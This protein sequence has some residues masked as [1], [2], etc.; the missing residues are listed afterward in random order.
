MNKR[1]LLVSSLLLSVAG[2]SQEKAKDSVEANNEKVLQTVE[3]I[4]RARKDYSSDYSF[5]SSKIA[6]KNMEVAQSI[7][8]VTKELLA[9][10]QVFR[11][12][13]AVK[14]VSGVTNTS[15]YNHYSI[16]GVTQASGNREN[17]LINGMSTSTYYF[18]QPLT[19]N[20]ERIEVIKGPA[21][22][23]FSSTDPG[24]TINLVTKKPLKNAR[25]E[26]SFTVGSYGTVRGALDFTGPLN[27]SK[28]LLYRLNIGYE[29]SQSYRDLQ[30]KKAYI[31]A[32]TISYIPNE[33][34]SVNVEFVL[35]DDTS[36]L[37]RG[38]PIY[39]VKQGEKPSLNTT[40]I[41]LAVGAPNDYNRNIDL[42]IMG[43]LTHKFT[44]D[45]NLNMSYMKHIWNEDLSEH[46]ANGANA[47]VADASGKYTLVEVRYVARQQ[48]FFTDNFNAY[49]N[50]NWK[51]GES[52]KNKTVFGYDIVGFE[53]S[54]TGGYNQAR[55][56]A[57]GVPRFDLANPKYY[58]ENPSAYNFVAKRKYQITPLAYTTN[59][60][61]LMNHMEWNKFIF[62][63]GLRQ[64]WFVD[65]YNYKIEGKEK[66]SR[67]NKFSKRF[68]LMYKANK[69]I[70]AYASY[71]EGFQIQTDAYI[72][73]DQY[74]FDVNGKEVYKE[75]F[76]PAS[77]RMWE[78]GLK[79]EWLNGKLAANVAYFNIKQRNILIEDYADATNG[80][81]ELHN[82]TDSRSQGIE[83]DVTGRILPNL[84]VNAGYSYIDAYFVEKDGTKSEKGN[85]PKHSFNLWSRY[86]VR[87]GVL[88]NFGVGAG[89]NYVGEKRA[90]LERNNLTVPSYAVVDAAVYYKLKD[91]Q[92]AVNVSNLFNTKYWL[93]AFDY[94]RLFPGSP[95]NVMLNVRY[96]F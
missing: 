83:V 71:I 45:I 30:F 36:R 94:T 6:L 42:S 18:N 75:P 68:G 48:K 21:S 29:N 89:L 16:R 64:E 1:V 37:D 70:N 50:A 8:S 59:G 66:V 10:R 88:R 17:R 51:I 14:N 52:I 87:E 76:G 93:G 7:S 86:D 20:I 73:S 78:G 9:D 13:D 4:G 40:P 72:G 26:V 80:G 60:I 23:A 2:F 35:S 63:F 55:G 31:I 27:E 79:T 47:L 62:S 77:S 41:S 25:K 95:R 46:R 65:K 39:G 58:L 57:F 24:G 33:K 53:V 3:L 84:Q 28:S 15:F 34:T 91:M 85:T 19:V 11:L 82:P 38:Q 54:R 69:N 67:Q 43:N 49:L 81:G 44:D 61:Y 74:R 22:M 90:W 56:L 96:T 32:P 5:S 92:I 12:G